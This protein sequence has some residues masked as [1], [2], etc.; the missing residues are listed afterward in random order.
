MIYLAP[1]LASHPSLK[2]LDLFDNEIGDQG[3]QAL[4]QVINE[5]KSLVELN[6]F[7]NMIGDQGEA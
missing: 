2:K 5:S 7:D 6:L 1:V 3:A 4:A